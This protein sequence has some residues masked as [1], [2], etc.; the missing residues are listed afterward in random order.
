MQKLHHARLSRRLA[1]V[2][3]TAITVAAFGTVNA[4]AETVN[5][6]AQKPMMASSFVSSS[7][8]PA[9]AA[10]NNPATRWA[11]A[12]TDAEW[13]QVDLGSAQTFNTVTFVWEQVAY[14]RAYNLQV[15]NDGSTWKTVYNT[16][17]GSY[18]T[19]KIAFQTT[20]AR[21]V[22]MQGLKRATVYGY[23]L[24]EFKV[25]QEA[26]NTVTS[27]PTVNALPTDKIFAP[28]SFWYQQIPANAPLHP[29]SANFT[30]EFNRQIKAYYG[31]VTINTTS[32]SSPVYTA[33]AGT[34]TT[35]VKFWD[36][37]GKRYT[38]PNLVNQWSAVPI[39]SYAEPATGSDLEMT[40]YQP[41]TDTIWEFWQTKNQGGVWQACWGGRLMNASKSDGIWP[42]YY[43]TTATGLPFLGG[44]IT[45]EELQRGE[46]RHAIGI[47][48]VDA[49]N[50]DIFSWPANRS[51]G[52]NPLKVPNRIAEGQRFRLD[53]TINVDA[54]NIHPM[55]KIIAKAAQ[56]YGFVVWDKAGA[57]SLRVQNPKSYTVLGQPNPYKALFN[58]TADYAVLNGFPW[59]R[60]QF[61]PMNYGKP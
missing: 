51:D 55:A 44:Q 48:L 57:I 59:N 58:G 60:L 17:T 42:L 6:A 49:E 13:I 18:G 26:T 29:N 15:S 27:A 38:D 47:A 9:A 52:S 31:N 16:S 14:A 1:L 33:A 25:S 7:Y 5:L 56:K 34:P 11:S 39:P 41:S 12:H 32:Y 28:T 61:L 53:P 40:V 19:Q 45:A 37:Q 46:I 30:A 21:F 4:S 20:S 10:D 35:A 36:C 50:W 43:G 2:Y 8:L 23:S 54:L 3:G 22:R 24:Y